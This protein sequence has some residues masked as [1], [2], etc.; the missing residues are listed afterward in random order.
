MSDYRVRELPEPYKIAD[1][2]YG[3]AVNLGKDEAG[4]RIRHIA[5]G[6]TEQEVRDKIHRWLVDE[7]LLH[8][9]KVALNSQSTI[10]ELAEDFKL[11]GLKDSGITDVTY[12]NYII[13]I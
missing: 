5:T 13:V 1:G 4:K 11:R 8:E 9:E 6:K 2:R 10:E 3:M 7:G 12:D